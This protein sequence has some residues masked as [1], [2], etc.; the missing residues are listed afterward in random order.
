MLYNIIIAA[1]ALLIV[2]ITVFFIIRER[3]FLTKLNLQLGTKDVKIKSLED[4][5]SYISELKGSDTN[6]SDSLK[7][8]SSEIIHLSSDLSYSIE[9]MNISMKEIAAGAGNIAKEADVQA[10]DVIKLADYIGDIHEK[11][12][13]NL[14][15]SEN[16][17]RISSESYS[18]MLYR[19]SKIESVINGFDN[20]MNNI[21][22]LKDSISKLRD[23]NS[24]IEQMIAGIKHISSQ[25]NLLALNA[26]IEAARAGEYG[27]GF[28]V[29]ATEVKKLADESS[30]VVESIIGVI[31]DAAKDTDYSNQVMEQSMKEITQ[32]YELLKSSIEDMNEI[33]QDMNSIIKGVDVL[34]E[35]DRSLAQEYES[36]N[37]KIVSLSAAVENN[38]YQVA[39]VTT[40]IKDETHAV[41]SMQ[42]ISKKLEDI[43]GKLYKDFLQGTRD[44][45]IVVVAVSEYPPFLIVEDEGRKIGGIDLDIL[46]EAFKKRGKS[47][48][49]KPMSFEKSL[50]MLQ[51]GFVDVV[52][53]LSYN[54][55]REKFTVFSSSYRNTTDY[56]FI[57]A[58]D[59][60]V[61]VDSHNDLRKYTVGVEKDFAYPKEF[62]E[63]KE[64][65][66]EESISAE[67]MITKL[68]KGQID[69]AII[70]EFTLVEILKKNK[71]E[72][73]LRKLE[74][75]ITDKTSDS[76]MGF[77]REKNGDGLKEFFEQG[78]KEI[79][80]D[81]TLD[82][83]YKKYIK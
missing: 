71:L 32:Q 76:R 74:Y 56:V 72:G 40:S 70:N 62:I 55:E 54:K 79:S 68:I 3:K 19:K 20:V 51:L 33:Q 65:R 4:I 43:S 52:P 27:K 17:Y 41:E 34:I 30:K 82:K 36:M 78:F 24:N 26:S 6:T 64:I 15:N 16:T 47:I 80:Q 46:S 14:E 35:N 81:G 31:S 49:F 66:R 28:N 75:R 25:T 44:A 29:V 45:D 60:G 5:K 48:E 59:K 69:T 18:K 77:S 63:D 10:N 23:K 37:N 7:G 2:V 13:Q 50:R 83:I 38:K 57:A 12:E 9:E 21:Y 67:I 58:S 61:R 11:S 42:S 22:V 39:T 73:K 8:I 53:T 1:L